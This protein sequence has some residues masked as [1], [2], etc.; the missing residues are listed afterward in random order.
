MM[1]MHQAEKPRNFG[2]FCAKSSAH[3]ELREETQ[4]IATNMLG[5]DAII[6]LIARP[7]IIKRALQ[8]KPPG[9]LSLEHHRD[10]LVVCPILRSSQM[11]AIKSYRNKNRNYPLTQCHWGKNGSIQWTDNGSMTPQSIEAQLSEG[12]NVRLWC[13]FSLSSRVEKGEFAKE[14]HAWL[15]NHFVLVNRLHY[16]YVEIGTPS[17]TYFVTLDTGSDLLWVPCAHCIAC[18]PSVSSVYVS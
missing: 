1:N 12:R 5:E 10:W 2:S 15:I 17:Q 14:C 18:A 6:N 8:L 16:T 4:P 11:S 13:L 9:Q 7:I 3:G